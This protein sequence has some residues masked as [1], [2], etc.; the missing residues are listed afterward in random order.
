MR[1]QMKNPVEVITIMEYQQ[2]VS[3][4]E[5]FSSGTL[6][7]LEVANLQAMLNHLAAMQTALSRQMETV[8]RHSALIN[9]A[10]GMSNGMTV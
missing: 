1:A 7:L 5:Q 6:I 9:A 3:K 2:R 10:L 4:G 8:E